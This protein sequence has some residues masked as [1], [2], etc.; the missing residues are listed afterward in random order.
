MPILLYRRGHAAHVVW[1]WL[2]HELSGIILEILL[3]RCKCW[4]EVIL[5]HVKS[6]VL[7]IPPDHCVKTN[8]LPLKV[9]VT[10]AGWC[11]TLRRGR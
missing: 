3:E 4:V 7:F 8:I 10:V 11:V 6:D 1:L 5:Q 9:L 2:G